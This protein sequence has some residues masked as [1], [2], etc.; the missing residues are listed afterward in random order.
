MHAEFWWIILERDF[1]S[2]ATTNPTSQL[3][4]SKLLHLETSI[5]LRELMRKVGRR[6]AQILVLFVI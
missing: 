1:A 6:Y 5:L 2:E 3:C 4:L